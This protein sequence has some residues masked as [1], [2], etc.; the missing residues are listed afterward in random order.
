[1]DLGQLE[2][3]SGEDTEEEGEV[4]EAEEEGEESEEEATLKELLRQIHEDDA[5][6]EYQEELK[7]KN[8]T[9][10]APEPVANKQSTEFARAHLDD[11]VVDL[12]ADLEKPKSKGIREQI[13]RREK[14]RIF[15][16]KYRNSPIVDTDELR[17]QTKKDES[18]EETLAEILKRQRREEIG[19]QYE[20]LP[21]KSLYE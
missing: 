17:R 2:G 4:S 7:R 20:H 14:E 11:E 9:R 21:V 16:Q 3:M 5:E 8:K 12:Y 6:F 19:K 13:R 18:D 1:M 15:A 10:H